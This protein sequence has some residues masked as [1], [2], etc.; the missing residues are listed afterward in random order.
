MSAMALHRQLL[1]VAV[2]LCTAAAAVVA[3]QDLGVG[4]ALLQASAATTSGVN[5]VSGALSGVIASTMRNSAPNYTGPDYKLMDNFAEAMERANISQA[6]GINDLAYFYY[7][8]RVDLGGFDYPSW[9]TT[10]GMF[11]RQRRVWLCH[12]NPESWADPR[13]VGVTWFEGSSRRFSECHFTAKN[14]NTGTLSIKKLSDP[15]RWAIMS[16]PKSSDGSN[17]FE[18]LPNEQVLQACLDSRTGPNGMGCP[19]VIGNYGENN[20]PAG[21]NPE[22]LVCRWMTSRRG[23]KKFY[24]YGWTDAKKNGPGN[25]RANYCVSFSM[26]N[27]R[28]F[29][30]LQRD[31]TFQIMVYKNRDLTTKLQ[32]ANVGCGPGCRGTANWPLATHWPGMYAEDMTEGVYSIAFDLAACCQ[33]CQRT[34]GCTGYMWYGKNYN[35]CW[36]KTT[37]C[38]EQER[39][40]RGV[41]CFSPPPPDPQQC[42]GRASASAYNAIIP[43]ANRATF[44]TGNRCLAARWR[45]RHDLANCPTDLVVYAETP[46]DCCRACQV[47]NSMTPD[48]N[49]WCSAWTLYKV[50]RLCYIR[51]GPCNFNGGVLNLSTVS[52]EM[53]GGSNLLP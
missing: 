28:P 3:E 15:N 18:W 50:E 41:V 44:F 17:P 20:S 33:M 1:P 26:Q 37:E 47:Y 25:Y 49:Q 7:W 14:W 12:G 30:P 38:F 8:Y 29:E 31:G 34:F 52:A 24:V 23:T 21:V 13:V 42:V 4:R 53:V 40:T 5:T 19:A 43:V 16:M 45:D 10:P 11:Q 6:S 27:G 39:P 46:A 9:T 36:L 32:P 35:W 48:R 51:K 2:V 22:R